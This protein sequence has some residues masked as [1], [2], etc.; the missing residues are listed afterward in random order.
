MIIEEFHI[1]TF[2]L[3]ILKPLQIG[4]TVRFDA[5]KLKAD[6]VELRSHLYERV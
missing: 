6:L 4:K 2:Q 5:E 1:Y 3:P